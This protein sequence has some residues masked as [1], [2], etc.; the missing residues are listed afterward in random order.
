MEPSSATWARCRRGPRAK[1]SVGE[2]DFEAVVKAARL[3]TPYKDFNRQPPVERDLN[4]VVAEATSWEAIERSIRDAAPPTLE[5]IRPVDVYRGE[6][7]DKGA[8]A[9]NCRIVF[10]AADRTLTASE[11]EA[12]MAAFLKSLKQNLGARLR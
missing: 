11:V 8:K 5:S 12:A 1:I 4:V 6:K 10:R 2:V 3:L 9:V 7:I